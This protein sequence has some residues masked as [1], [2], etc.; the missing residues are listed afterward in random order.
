LIKLQQ[1]NIS[2]DMRISL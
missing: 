1:M 2:I